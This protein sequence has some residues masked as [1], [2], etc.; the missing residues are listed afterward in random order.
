[1][2]TSL[3][4]RY[5]FRLATTS[6]IHPADYT[7][8]VRRLAPLVDE[9]ELLFLE[10]DHL[11]S[12]AEI[13]ELKELSDTL[14]IGYN[15]HLPMDISLADPSV[16][17]RNRSQDAILKAL[18]RVGPLNASTHTIHVTYREADNRPDTVAAWQNR[19]VGSLT[20]ILQRAPMMH[21]R[22]SVETLDFPPRYLSLI[23]HQLDLP[24]CVDVGHVIRFGF[25]L[26]ETLNQFSGRI[27]I[28]HLHGVTGTRDHRA[29]D[30]LPCEFRR[31]IIPLLKNFCGTVSLEV[32]SYPDLKDSLSCFAQMMTWNPGRIAEPPCRY[33]PN[34]STQSKKN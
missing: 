20:R 9:I 2:P 5:P 19:A 4:R 15:V 27:A 11:P 24:V 31:M 6:F 10:R 1:M 22:L 34:E 30:H 16:S 18:E 13:N 25:D 8:N 33:D 12:V 23:A 7:V 17:I 3:K 14:D 29:L 32:F 26:Q 21:K 28:F